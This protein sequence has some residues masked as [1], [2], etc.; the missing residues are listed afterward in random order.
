VDQYLQVW[1]T[2]RSWTPT[3]WYRNKTTPSFADAL[4]ALRTCLWS[5]RI[6]PLCS[7]G[8]LPTKIRDELIGVLAQ[9]A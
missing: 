1:G 5:Q 8:P 4:A 6:T 2:R 7:T 3:P 9:A